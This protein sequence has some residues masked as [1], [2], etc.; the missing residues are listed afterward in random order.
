MCHFLSFVLPYVYFFTIAEKYIND[1]GGEM[2]YVNFDTVKY[3]SDKFYC[4]IE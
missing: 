4:F 2:H 3:H 1:D